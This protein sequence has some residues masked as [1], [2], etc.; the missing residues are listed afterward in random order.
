MGKYSRVKFGNVTEYD[1]KK[2]TVY[3][4]AVIAIIDARLAL[5]RFCIIYF[6]QPFW[7]SRLM[8]KIE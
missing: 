2:N 3:S 5:L 1:T 4:A 8:E 6:F 7:F